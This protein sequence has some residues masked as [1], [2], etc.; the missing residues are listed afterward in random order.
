[1]NIYL[2]SDSF[3]L[4]L[5]NDGKP[6]TKKSD[7]VASAS[8][9]KSILSQDQF[10]CLLPNY[11]L[12]MFSI[13]DADFAEWTNDP[14]RGERLHYSG[15]IEVKLSSHIGASSPCGFHGRSTEHGKI[16]HNFFP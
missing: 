10:N 9:G 7:S 2:V 4:W 15:L 1:M 13:K 6:K 11:M 5:T 16:Y 3:P 8:Q 12:K 14:L